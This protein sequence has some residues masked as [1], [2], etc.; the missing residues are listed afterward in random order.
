MCYM[1]LSMSSYCSYFDYMRDA[2]FTPD[3]ATSGIRYCIIHLSKGSRT[4]AGDGG[5][6]N[7][8]FDCSTFVL[9]VHSNTFRD[10]Y[11]VKDA[12]AYVP[13]DTEYRNPPGWGPEDYYNRYGFAFT[14]HR[15]YLIW[16]WVESIQGSLESEGIE[17]CCI[18]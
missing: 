1:T 13:I 3:R 11:N 10:A 16:E 17:I 9:L 7:Y 2:I 18:E 12:I 4:G 8:P 15:N 5:T 14:P 6:I